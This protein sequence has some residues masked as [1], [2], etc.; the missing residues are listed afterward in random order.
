MV[1]STGRKLSHFASV[2][3]RPAAQDFFVEQIYLNKLEV[4]GGT[5]VLLRILC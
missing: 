2:S 4:F 1:S 3:T 5:Q